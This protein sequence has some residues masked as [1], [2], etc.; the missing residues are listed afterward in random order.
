[1]ILALTSVSSLFSLQLIY[2]KSEK[3]HLAEKAGNLL[4]VKS[5]G[6]SMGKFTAFT[7]SPFGLAK[8][9]RRHSVGWPP[10]NKLQCFRVQ[11]LKRYFHLHHIGA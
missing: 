11:L 6:F 2:E 4:E 9:K 1:M 3:S 7:K 10:Y 5:K 8:T